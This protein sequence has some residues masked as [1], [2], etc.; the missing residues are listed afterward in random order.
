MNHKKTLVPAA[1]GGS[2]HYH[3]EGETDA[4]SQGIGNMYRVLLLPHL[5]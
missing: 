2:T 5:R 4:E 3:M 1:S